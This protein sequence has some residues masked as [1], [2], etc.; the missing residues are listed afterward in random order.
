MVSNTEVREGSTVADLAAALNAE[1]IRYKCMEELRRSTETWAQEGDEI[2]NVE[3]GTKQGIPHAK[4]RDRGLKNES[5]SHGRD[6]KF[7]KFGSI[8]LK[9][10]DVHIY[11]YIYMSP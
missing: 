10:K 6:A 4:R 11:I 7:K 3:L 9:G 2:A 8:T 1:I 5:D